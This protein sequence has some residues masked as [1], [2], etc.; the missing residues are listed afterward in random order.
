[1][2]RAPEHVPRNAN[3]RAAAAARDMLGHAVG[4][5]ASGRPDSASRGT[6]RHPNAIDEMMSL[7]VAPGGLRRAEHDRPLM[8]PREAE[9]RGFGT[10][11]AADTAAVWAQ[12]RAGPG[13]IGGG[14]EEAGVTVAGNA[15]R[16]QLQQ[17]R[18]AQVRLEHAVQ[19]QSDAIHAWEADSP[20]AGVAGPR[21]HDEERRW[22]LRLE[23]TIEL[24]CSAAEEMAA[25]LSM[26]RQQG[27]G[28]SAEQLLSNFEQ[29]Q[30]LMVNSMREELRALGAAVPRHSATPP[31]PAAPSPSVQGGWAEQQSLLLLDVVE[32]TEAASALLEQ[33]GGPRMRR[34]PAALPT[35]HPS[36]VQ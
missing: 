9:R 23:H 27:R 26:A 10:G 22:L 8:A 35:K 32:R 2:L 18:L 6:R 5:H 3:Q 24:H 36:T 28:A 31:P 15:P 29:Q 13:A 4:S 30:A 17:W 21:L 11:T 16:A 34:P 33:S 20:I 12:N 7:R 1:M 19:S 14:Q 25:G